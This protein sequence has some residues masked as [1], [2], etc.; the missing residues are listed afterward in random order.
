MTDSTH[1]IIVVGGGTAGLVTA[2]GAAALG[3]KA[4][5]IERTALGGDCLWTGCVPSK[6]LIAFAR[7]R[8]VSGTGDWAA[9]V[10][11]LRAARDRVAKHDE[12]E[13]FRGMGVDV[14]LSPAR[15]TGPERVE[16][17]G[18][19]LRAR[20]IVLALGSVPAVP[21][22][23][24]LAEAGF[25]TNVTCFDRPTLPQRLIM[26]GGGPIG[27][28]LAQTYH[29]L[30]T[31]VTVLEL[32]PEV[33]P[34]EDAEVGKFVRERLVEEGIA[35][36]T[37]C[38][39]ERVAREGDL[40]VIHAT[41][42][43]RFGGDEIFVATGRQP[44]TAE[45]EPERAGVELDRGAVRVNARLE[46][47]A[48]G[49][50]AAGDVTGGLQFTHVADYMAKVVVQNALTPLKTKADYRVVPWVTFTDPEVARVGLTAAEA[51]ARGRAVET[52]RASF[53]ELDRAIVDGV[54]VGFSKVVTRPNGEILGATLV[55]R[56]AGELIMEIVVAMRHRIPLGQL[57]RA[58]HPYPTMSEIVRQTADAWYRARYGDTV[59]GRMLRRFIRWWL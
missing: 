10:A 24:G 50:W 38:R 27:L 11:W 18:R 44:N 8:Q 22:I 59:R 48:P 17:D 9:G 45:A 23:P 12:P 47:T 43:R 5:L 25:L 57:A 41:D 6:A 55:G 1:D 51:A 56:G 7:R 49:I 2:A 46:T 37:G 34:K 4:A 19:E 53:T 30:G 3:A 39:A 16:V 36:V 29:R 54:A 32:L 33:L 28:E 42:G 58:I 21:P 52:F 15:L 40:K 35:I 20:R 13:R 14:I 26:L 31:K